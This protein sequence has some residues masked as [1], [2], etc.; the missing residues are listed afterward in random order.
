MLTTR[1]EIPTIYVP[2]GADFV[3]KASQ[4]YDLMDIL[5]AATIAAATFSIVVKTGDYPAG[6]TLVTITGAIVPG[7]AADFYG[8]LKDTDTSALSNGQL[9]WASFSLNAGADALGKAALKLR[10]VTV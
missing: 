8:I 5:S 10:F 6:S 4:V 9:G 3:F 2:I 7:A 1:I